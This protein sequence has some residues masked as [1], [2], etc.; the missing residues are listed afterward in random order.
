MYYLKKLRKLFLYAGLK[1]EEFD[2]LRTSIHNENSI[3]LRVF[4][5]LAAVMFFL[6]LIASML[7]K[8]FAAVNS[9]TYLFCGMAMLAIQ[10]CAR[11]VVPKH[12]AHIMLLVYLFEITL[13][14]FGINISMLHADKPAVSAV[15][16]LLVTPLLFYDRP[17][18]I[19]SL[20]LIVA[21]V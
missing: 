12:P 10:L 13:Y 2:D 21:V 5:Q 11:A 14:A 1:R 20:I 6:L 8:G 4:S 15:A 16:F 9:Q 19:S 18:R 7:T 17:I 3:L